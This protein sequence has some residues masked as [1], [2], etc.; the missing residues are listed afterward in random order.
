MD[1]GQR[2]CFTFIPKLIDV[3]MVD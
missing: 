3:Y 2:K 1:Q